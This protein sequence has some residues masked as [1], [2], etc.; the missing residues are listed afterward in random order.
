M[1]IRNKRVKYDGIIYCLNEEEKTSDVID[2]MTNKKEIK[3]PSYIK[4]ETNEYSVTSIIKNS[5]LTSELKSLSF[6][7][8]SKLQMIDEDAFD[9]SSI[10]TISIPSSITEI[11]KYA[12]N[13]CRKLR[14]IIIPINSQLQKIDEFAFKKS[15]IE[16][17]TIP[18]HVT[19]ICSHAFSSCKRLQN[20]E[21]SSNSELQKIDDYV[22]RVF[23]AQKVI[24]VE[25][26]TEDIVFRHTINAMPENVR[27]DIKGKYQIV[28]ATG[29]ATMISFIK[30]FDF[31]HTMN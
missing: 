18:P 8:D 15:T 3:I 10:E 29:K 28:K 9:S 16:S 11:G 25:G 12:F 26:D 22:A 13:M 20:V 27:K 7:E 19:C 4:H 6:S 1:K 5:F 31:K 23:F 14:Q 24:I 17:I 2:F 21:F 30:Y